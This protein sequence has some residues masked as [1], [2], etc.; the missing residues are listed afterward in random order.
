MSVNVERKEPGKWVVCE[1]YGDMSHYLTKYVF[2][3][4]H[5]QKRHVLIKSKESC[6]MLLTY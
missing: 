3:C 5:F 2:V 6:F 4:M 1:C